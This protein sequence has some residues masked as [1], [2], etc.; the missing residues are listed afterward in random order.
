MLNRPA[1]AVALTFC[2]GVGITSLP[3]PAHAQAEGERTATELYA[4]GLADLEAGMVEAARDQL[5][6]VDPMQLPKEQR[7]R[8]YEALRQLDAAANGDAATPEPQA[9]LGAPASTEAALDAPAPGD[10]PAEP[11]AKAPLTPAQEAERQ[12]QLDAKTTQAKRLLDEASDQLAGGDIAL[13]EASLQA[14]RDLQSQGAKL[15]WFDQQRLQTQLDVIADQRTQVAAA[16]ADKA[17]AAAAVAAAT[18]AADA[19][20]TSTAQAEANAAAAE[21]EAAKEQA[22]MAL[23]TAATEEAMA[24]AAA[25]PSQDL[26][27]AANKAYAADL[28]EDARDAQRNGYDQLAISLFT[29]ASELDP[30]NANI[31]ANLAAARDAADAAN[32]PQVDP[33]AAQ[34]QLDSLQL[35]A[36][37]DAYDASMNDARA[38]L[39]GKRFD[40]ASDA[41]TSAKITLDRNA[42]LYATT[43][44]NQRRTTA[45]DLLVSIQRAE[46][47]AIRA[48]QLADA[49]RQ[50]DVERDAQAEAIRQQRERT[51]ALIGQSRDLQR[52]MRY[53]EALD[54][55]NQALFIDPQ[56]IAAHAL[57][58]ILEDMIILRDQRDFVRQRDLM[59]SRQHAINLEATI[60]YD[61]LLVYPSDW[62]Q[63]TQ[64][65]LEALDESGGES[66]INREAAQKLEQVVPVQFEANPLEAVIGFLRTTTGVN[67]FVNWP[68]LN[69]EG[70]EEDMP[71]TLELADVSARVALE[72]VLQLANAAGGAVSPATYS[73]VD[74][75]V[76]INTQAELNRSTEARVYDIRDLLV[77]VPNF[78]DAPSF[79]LSEALS[80]NS[81][82]GGGGGSSIFGDEEEDDEDE[83][84]QREELI[85]QIEDIIRESVGRLEEWDTGDSTIREL[86][87]NLIIKTTAGNHRDV[88]GVLGDLREQ[89]ATQISVE[90]R[91]LLVD[92]NFLEEFGIDLD[93]RY[94]STGNFTPVNVEQNSF[95]LGQRG[96]T[97]LT[98]SRF[99][100]A[101]ATGLPN[102]LD[103]GVS[104]IDDLEVDLL[105]RATQASNRSLTLTAPR[106][107][108]FNGQRAYVLVATEVAFISDL[109]PVP[110]TNSFDVTVSSVNSGVVLDVEGTVS[111]DRRYVT[112][113][114]RPSLATLQQ[115]IRQIEITGAADGLSVDDGGGLIGGGNI[116]TGTIE[117]P[118]LEVTQVRST[119]SVPDKGTLL[120]GGQRL[121]GEVDIEAGVPVLNK[122]P[123]INRLFTNNSIVK[124]ERTL[125]ILIKPTIILQSEQEEILFPGLNDDPA[126]FNVGNTF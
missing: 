60:P 70:I 83:E 106:V 85:Q 43:A 16:Q 123:I 113:T 94:E 59:I 54:L 90:A 22:R 97:V 61:D 92:N 48:N 112:M 3:A 73:I 27:I 1:F 68:A 11:E 57:Q 9:V 38:A 45:N 87:G 79:E 25:P 126:K 26:L 91:F 30:D 118:E 72:K 96:S 37:N 23:E 52:Q 42:R 21:A 40:E 110:D 33:L 29:E 18:A 69:I 62:P 34:Q 66:R 109:E 103:F 107:T 19:P 108:F 50:K 6:R 119:V 75:V 67:I 55:I 86:N 36:A 39:A 89:R 7:V 35:Q 58:D 24:P 41:V 111:A 12:R 49:R 28:A 13:A 121:V 5:Y 82:G 105:V 63:L 10:G 76:E 46:E 104:F 17:E 53:E 93:V 117:L 4:N 116:F 80:G 65:R 15:G 122:I 74:G 32:V 8:L 115:P 56:N 78:T 100:G 20:D 124:D 95:E 98:P 51:N 99:L 125:L 114:M 31:Q 47:E 71:I 81:G 84:E 2:V 101:G 102:A 64:R 88:L 120:L 77:Q 14:A 44:Y